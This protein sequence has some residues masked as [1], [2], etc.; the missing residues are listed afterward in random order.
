MVEMVVAKERMERDVACG[1]G[2][3]K[4]GPVCVG[5]T[6]PPFAIP[7]PPGP[8]LFLWSPSSPRHYVPPSFSRRTHLPEEALLSRSRTRMSR[9]HTHTRTH[10][11][12][13]VHSV[14]PSRSTF[15]NIS[16]PPDLSSPFIPLL[17]FHLS[18][19]HSPRW[20]LS[21]SFAYWTSCAHMC[22]L[23]S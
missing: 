4:R 3:L 8:S 1:P 23:L 10:A 5:R 13:H 18:V 15:A 9:A 17:S 12:V 16:R 22:R 20:N 7:G 6:A 11:R 2:A 14:F 19:C 21:L